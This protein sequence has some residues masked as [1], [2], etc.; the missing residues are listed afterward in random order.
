MRISDWSSDVCS[1]DLLD[2]AFVIVD[3]EARTGGRRHAQMLHQRLGAMVP[4]ADRHARLVQ[5]GADVM[6]M[7]AVDRKADDAGRVLRPEQAHGVDPRQPF[8]RQPPQR[9]GAHTSEL[10]YL[11][12]N[13]YAVFF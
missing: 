2:I 3:A 7:R 8:P 11:R 12:R 10:Q 1:S 13:L 9:S 4:G 5:Y 6:R